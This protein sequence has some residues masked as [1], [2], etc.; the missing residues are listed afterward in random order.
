MSTRALAQS[1]VEHLYAELKSDLAGH[2]QTSD[3]SLK[4][5]E[6]HST[7]KSTPCGCAPSMVTALAPGC[8]VLPFQVWCGLGKQ[9]LHGRNLEHGSGLDQRGEAQFF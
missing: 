1:A 8:L 6:G 7:S 5:W 4:D 3:L 2:T 9:E